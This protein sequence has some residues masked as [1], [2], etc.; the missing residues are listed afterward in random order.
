MPPALES[1]KS[2]ADVC[3]TDLPGFMVVMFKNTNSVP[4]G[5]LTTWF[6]RSVYEDVFLK[7]QTE[8]S[9]VGDIAHWLRLTSKYFVV[10]AGPGLGVAIGVTI[11][12]GV[13]VAVANGPAGP[14]VKA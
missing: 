9:R 2:L 4:G 11:G 13:G 6:V 12:V 5:A 3:K 7:Q 8:T 14:G 10:Y 1:A